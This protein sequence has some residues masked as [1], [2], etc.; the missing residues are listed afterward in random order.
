[1]ILKLGKKKPESG[2]DF[3]R[4]WGGFDQKVGR[5]CAESGE[6]IFKVREELT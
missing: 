1:M 2:E 3:T 6:D 4:S 5:I